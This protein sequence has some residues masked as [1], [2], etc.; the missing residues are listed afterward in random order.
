MKLN[1]IIL[2]F[3]IPL[4]VLAQVPDG[5]PDPT[6][7]KIEINMCY[8]D[9]DGKAV[10]DVFKIPEVTKDN[11]RVQLVENSPRDPNRTFDK[12][13]NFG[14]AK[15]HWWVFSQGINRAQ[16]EYSDC[17]ARISEIQKILKEPQIDDENLFDQSFI[18]GLKEYEIPFEAIQ[19][20]RNISNP[21]S[22]EDAIEHV[23][24]A[25]V[26]LNLMVYANIGCQDLLSQKRNDLFKY[27]DETT[28]KINCCKNRKKHC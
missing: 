3:L 18:E 23:K 4:N 7:N 6:E 2:F 13:P 8:E 5:L 22:L 12:I 25:V 14:L 26:G 17:I 27:L 19:N 15:F 20:T 28:I 16:R 10:C 11:S 9:T 1:F 24:A 21:P